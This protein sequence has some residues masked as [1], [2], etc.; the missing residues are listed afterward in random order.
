MTFLRN[1]ELA[2]S[3]GSTRLGGVGTV[4]ERSPELLEKWAII[5]QGDF[6]Q[7]K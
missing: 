5:Q 6:E 1:P 7:V 3:L 4:G 2:G